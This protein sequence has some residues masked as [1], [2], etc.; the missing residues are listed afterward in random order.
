LNKEVL[1]D[2]G[3]R[4]RQEN[5]KAIALATSDLA[6]GKK[7]YKSSYTLLN[8]PVGWHAPY[9]S[10]WP[11]IP[12]YGTLIIALSP[13]ATER[14]GAYHGFQTS[15]IDRLVS[16]AKDTG[17]VAFVLNGQPEEYVGLDFL[18]PIF[19][20]F[21]PRVELGLFGTEF[22][23]QV[24]K[25]KEAFIEFDT[26]AS[27]SFYKY[28]KTI[29]KEQDVLREFGPGV[30]VYSRVKLSANAFAALEMLGY[31]EIKEVISRAL[32]EEPVLALRLLN[33]LN[34]LI[35][36]PRADPFD[37]IHNVT[38]RT[39]EN[40]IADLGKDVNVR[41]DQDSH[42][43]IC[44][45]G[46][47]L[48]NKLSPYPTSFE[49]CRA[50]CDTYKHYDLQQVMLALQQAA[51]AEDYSEIKSESEQLSEILEN[52]WNDTSK[53]GSRV[54][55]IRAGIPLSIAL[56]GEVA[57]GPIGAV[58]GGLLAKLGYEVLEKFMEMKT[59]SISE[60]IAKYSAPNYLVNVFNFKKRY[61]LK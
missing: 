28:A 56:L 10:I 15:D 53:I 49:A 1:S 22:T 61:D 52:I 7:Y 4:E 24:D 47:F 20:E 19:T 40:T 42:L 39:I 25:F 29:S 23:S 37:A 48:M 57:A 5:K 14:F 43:S 55:L 2:Y 32:T 12:I 36:D 60:K 33:T 21:R 45:I 18:N 31:H 59:D 16:F 26:L 51:R 13:I 27:L 50:M 9:E 30:D 41:L 34:T 3:L 35:V 44:E 11:Q 46:K 6:A 17:H 54:N 8:A 58:T 38:Q